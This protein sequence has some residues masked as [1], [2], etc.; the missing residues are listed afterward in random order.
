MPFLPLPCFSVSP[1]RSSGCPWPPRP[2]RPPPC[3]AGRTSRLPWAQAVRGPSWAEL[4]RGPVGLSSC[5]EHLHPSWQPFAHPDCCLPLSEWCPEV[6]GLRE[7]TRQCDHPA[8]QLFAEEPGAG[9][10][11]P[12]SCVCGRG[13]T[14]L[15][16][17]PGGRG[18]GRAPGAARGSARLGRGDVRAVCRPRGPARAVAGGNGLQGGLGGV[19]LPPGAGRLAPRGHLQD[20]SICPGQD[21]TARRPE[22]PA[23]LSQ[24]LKQPS[25]EAEAEPGPLGVSEAGPPSSQ[26]GGNRDWK[27]L[28]RLP[29]KG[30][31][32][33]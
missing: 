10:A 11:V 28:R 25:E 5:P 18:P 15:P 13:G 24:R 29:S 22:P 6:V 16:R 26:A 9:E 20:L 4:A 7:N 30:L 2:A 12:A 32:W 3:P 23:E 17:V 27:L 33:D 21:P 19:R 8:L 14:P 31:A 1:H